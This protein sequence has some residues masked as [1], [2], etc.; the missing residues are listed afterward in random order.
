MRQRK[1]YRIVDETGKFFSLKSYH[2]RWGKEINATY[3][4]AK[5]RAETWLPILPADAKIEIVSQDIF[6]KNHKNETLS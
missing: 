5:K 3:F 2:P 6:W 1:H 4:S